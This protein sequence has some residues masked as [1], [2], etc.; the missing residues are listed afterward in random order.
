MS[1][2]KLLHCGAI[3]LGGVLLCAQQ[4][5]SA[6]VAVVGLFSNKAVV[7][8]DG[9]GPKTLGVGQKFGAVTLVNVERG[10]ATFDIDGKRRSIRLG[11]SQ[12]STRGSA[13][14]T[15]TLTADGRGHHIADGQVNGQPI[16][17]VVDTGAS[18]VAISSADAQRMGIDYIKGELARVS[19]ANGIARAWRVKLDSV[20]VG[21]I[22]LS[23]VDAMV[24]ENQAMPALLGMSF[25]NRMEMRRDGEVMTLTKRY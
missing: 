21:D 9:N 7:V 20:R 14:P 23:G 18:L 19:T 13:N 2:R 10:S 24:M 1:R 22:T 3:V 16:R 4:A 8:V 25:L 15:V 5:W 6:D 11:E 17:F 12:V